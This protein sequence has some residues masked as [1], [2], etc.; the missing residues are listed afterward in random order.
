M[1]FKFFLGC[2]FMA[3]LFTA[4]FKVNPSTT[5]LHAADCGVT[6]I[7][8]EP[9]S[10]LGTEFYLG[11]QGG[12][13]PG[14]QN[15]PPENH[16]AAGLAI[17]QSIQPLNTQGLV[18]PNGEIVLASMGM[19]NVFQEFGEFVVL[20]NTDTDKNGNVTVANLAQPGVASQRMAKADDIYWTTRVPKA[21][22]KLNLTEEQVQILWLKQNRAFPTEPFPQFALLLKEDLIDIV[23]N[24]KATFPNLQMIFVSSRI[25]AGYSLED[26]N[27]EPYA[28][29][30][31][32]GVKWLIAAQINGD[33][34]LNFDPANGEVKAPFIDWGPYLWADGLT[35]RS[36]GLIWECKDFEADGVHPSEI[37]EEKVAT[38]LLNFFKTDAL[39]KQWF[40]EGNPLPPPGSDLDLRQYLP[41]IFNN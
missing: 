15:T 2:L 36:D 32:F 1:N 12:L 31:G 21:L 11:E 7:G 22:A 27:P 26:L 34:E 20:A 5:N 14:G 4:V 17:A 41:L 24:A 18:D 8:A 9:L 13:Y 3:G 10:D 38:S 28:Y 37:G 16:A 35:P 29:E 40:G 6:S 39:T 30:S 33:P 23:H 19:S 25:Y